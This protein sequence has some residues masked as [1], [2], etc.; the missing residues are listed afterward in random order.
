MLLQIVISTVQL[1]I[2]RDTRLEEGTSE[3]CNN[4]R[5]IVVI[6]MNTHNLTLKSRFHCGLLLGHT[7][8]TPTHG[9]AH[10]H[11]HRNITHTC[12]CIHF[13]KVI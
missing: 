3:L 8:C 12:G 7:G 11:T 1:V 5:I 2:L 9:R 10:A 4:V 6:I 13:M